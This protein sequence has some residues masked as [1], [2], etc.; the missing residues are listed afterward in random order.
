MQKN[1]FLVVSEK[2]KTETDRPR[3]KHKAASTAVPDTTLTAA[4]TRN[5]RTR[6]ASTATETQTRT[7]A[8]TAGT[9][10]TRT[11]P[12]AYS[13]TAPTRGRGGERNPQKRRKMALLLQRI[14][15]SH[16]EG[17]ELFPR[18]FAV[19]LVWFLIFGFVFGYMWLNSTWL[20]PLKAALKLSVSI[21]NEGCY[22]LT[23][24]TKPDQC[25]LKPTTVQPPP[26]PP[27]PT[28]SS[29]K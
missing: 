25:N 28:A 22:I 20:N 12:T 27:A 6:G 19:F 14:F 15:A 3:G 21:E 7:G 4:E 24:F 9:A 29:K 11:R 17:P 1:S 2:S 16:A 10:M 5:M 26:P 23:N 13:R 8:T 18:I